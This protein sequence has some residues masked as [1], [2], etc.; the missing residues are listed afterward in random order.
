MR[1]TA[2]LCTA[3]L[4]LFAPTAGAVDFAAQ[5]LD[6][7][8]DPVAGASVSVT[9]ALPGGQSLDRSDDTDQDGVAAFSTPRQAGTTALTVTDVALAGYTFDPAR[10]VLSGSVV[11]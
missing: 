2:A 6:A 9:W 3:I 11:G 5:V 1:T 10:S 4:T 8:G 7:S